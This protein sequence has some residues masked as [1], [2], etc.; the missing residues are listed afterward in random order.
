MFIFKVNF[1]ISV[2]WKHEHLN[3]KY[4]W[5]KEWVQL[6]KEGMSNCMHENFLFNY[7]SG[8]NV[9]RH[10]IFGDSLHGKQG[11]LRSTAIGRLVLH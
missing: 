9:P 4:L 11:L 8:N 5:L 1:N 7:L 10:H 6:D 2:A 3:M